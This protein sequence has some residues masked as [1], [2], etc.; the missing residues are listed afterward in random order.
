MGKIGERELRTA[1]FSPGL[2]GD[3]QRK[4]ALRLL[5]RDRMKAEDFTG[6][7][8]LGRGRTDAGDCA[9]L[10]AGAP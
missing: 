2:V 5:P 10:G 7:S 3:D 6:P 1:A 4:Q 9:D 8:Q